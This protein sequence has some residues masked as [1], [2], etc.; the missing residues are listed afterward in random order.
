M[1]SI[2][3]HSSSSPY[4]MARVVGAAAPVCHLSKDPAY[5]NQYLQDI[6]RIFEIELTSSQGNGVLSSFSRYAP[7]NP[8]FFTPQFFEGIENIRAKAFSEGLA[9]EPSLPAQRSFNLMVFDIIKE[10]VAETNDN[11]S[12]EFVPGETL[13]LG[14]KKERLSISLENFISRV[15]PKLLAVLLPG[16]TLGWRGCQSVDESVDQ[17]AAAE[18]QKE[19]HQD[20]LHLERLFCDDPIFRTEAVPISEAIEYTNSCVAPDGAPP[21]VVEQFNQ[22]KKVRLADLEEQADKSFSRAVERDRTARA[23]PQMVRAEALPAEA[24]VKP[25]VLSSPLTPTE[26]PADASPA[27]A[28]S[29]STEPGSVSR[30]TVDPTSSPVGDLPAAFADPA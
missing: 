30:S 27:T 20:R 3:P 8:A 15:Q 23:A 2:S 17:L 25:E 28:G 24:E 12:L 22:I 18:F 26:M 10:I 5:Y 29:G 21:E 13:M 11:T 16:T 19:L 1:C 9:V 14:L 6:H 7:I 4:A